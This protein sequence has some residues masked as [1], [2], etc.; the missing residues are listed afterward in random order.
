MASEDEISNR[1]W[2]EEVVQ[3]KLNTMHN[4]K[5]VWDKIIQGMADGGHSDVHNSAVLKLTTSRKNIS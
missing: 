5:L 1:V 4:K 3:N 2:S